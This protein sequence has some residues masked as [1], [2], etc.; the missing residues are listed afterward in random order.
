MDI[1]ERMLQDEKDLMFQ[2]VN[3]R[4]ALMIRTMTVW[5]YEHTPHGG[6]RYVTHENAD[7]PN[8]VNLHC[9]CGATWT[10]DKL[11]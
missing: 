10:E 9:N 11:K 2:E 5:V 6:I 3:R 8:L 1:T 4:V 7:V